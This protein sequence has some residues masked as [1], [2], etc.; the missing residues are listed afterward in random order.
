MKNPIKQYFLRKRQRELRQRYMSIGTGTI[1]LRNDCLDMRLTPEN[2]KYVT[3]GE[4]GLIKAQFTF[5]SQQ[6]EVHIG[7]NTHIGGAQFICRSRIDVGHDV[8]MAWGITLYDHDSHSTNWEYRKHDNEQCYK[9]YV[10]TGNNI[11][12]KDWSHVN[13]SPIRIEDKVWIGM[14]VLV[15]KGVT[16]GEGSVVAARSVV[17]KDVPPYSLVAGNPARVVKSLK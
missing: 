17:T 4:R 3:I 14:D 1:L 10:E 11:A 12:N 5:E 2:R 9:D 16:I 8:T 7:N 6:G 13:T 15:L